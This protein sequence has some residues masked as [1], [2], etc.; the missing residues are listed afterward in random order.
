MIYNETLDAIPL[1]VYNGSCT[2]YMVFV[3]FL[4]TRT[5]IGT[6]FIYFYWYSKKNIANAYY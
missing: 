3:V 2:L 5:V 6:A 1:N 4:V